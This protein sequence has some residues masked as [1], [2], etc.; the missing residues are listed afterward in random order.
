MEIIF[1]N[2]E[3]TDGFFYHIL[4][5]HKVYDM[6]PYV[7]GTDLCLEDNGTGDLYVNDE[8]YWFFIN[9]L[10][11]WTDGEAP[12]LLAKNDVPDLLTEEEWITF[13]RLFHR[14]V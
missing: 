6:T 11:V 9:D 8:M 4:N 2:R 5:K 1:Y 13:N 7:D 12:T 3:T 14:I 10:F